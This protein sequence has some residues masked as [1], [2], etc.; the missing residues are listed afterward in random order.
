MAYNSIRKPKEEEFQQDD[1]KCQA[2]GCPCRA[3]MRLSSGWTCFAHA[4]ASPEDFQRVT[5][6][7]RENSWL[8]N[9][10]DEI[11]LMDKAGTDWRGFSNQFWENDPHCKPHALE[12]VNPYENRMRSELL[13]RCGQVSK[14]PEPRLPKEVKPGGVFKK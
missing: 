3:S 7:L 11:I 13:F 2:Y 12:N 6:L 8:G 9:F 14:R 10:I 5:T 4:Y 1:T